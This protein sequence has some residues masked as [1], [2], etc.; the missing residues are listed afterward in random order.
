MGMSYVITYLRPCLIFDQAEYIS[1]KA[2]LFLKFFRVVLNI[3]K[4]N[5]F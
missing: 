4:Q 2:F 5:K 1:I 3:K